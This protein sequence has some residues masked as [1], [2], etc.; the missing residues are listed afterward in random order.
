MGIARNYHSL[1]ALVSA[2]WYQETG[3][4]NDHDAA[5]EALGVPA[6]DAADPDA[7]PASPTRPVALPLRLAGSGRS[8]ARI[9]TSRTSLSLEPPSQRPFR[10][11]MLPPP[12]LR[13]RLLG[14]LLVALTLAPAAWAQ[15]DVLSPLD[16]A[17]MQTVGDV[18]VS[19]GG[20]YVAYTVSVPR[21]PFEENATPH[22]ELHVYDVEAGTSEGLWTGAVSVSG[23]GWTPDGERISLRTQ[24]E[25]DERTALYTL[26]PDGSDVQRFLMF[27]T[28]IGDYAWHPNGEAVAFVAPE[29]M[30]EE[31]DAVLPYEPEVYEEGV[32]DRHLWIA[33]ADTAPRKVD[34][35]GT[36]HGLAWSP[37]GDRLAVAAAPNALVDESYMDKRIRILDAET[38]RVLARIDNPG[39]LGAMAWSPSGR[40]LAFISAA[41]LNDPKDG[42]LM[43]ADATTGAFRDALPGLTDGQ[44]TSITWE[45]E[46]T[47]RYAV[48]RGVESG[49]ELVSWEGGPPE[50]LVPGGMAAFSSISAAE[51]G[52]VVAFAASTPMHAN[53]LFVMAEGDE[54]PARVTDLNPWLTAKRL[55][56][57]EVVTYEARDGL[58]L[59]GLLI[60]PLGRQDDRRYPAIIVVHGGPES[61]YRNGWLTGY[62][63][64][65]QMAAARGF[66][67]FYPNYR[68][69]TGRGVAFSKTSQA[70]PAGAEF[71]DIVDA[72]DHLIQIG[73]A[74]PDAI[75]VTGGSYGGYATGWLATRYSERFAAG[76]MFVGISNKVSK[77]GTT[78][79]P[80]E[81][82]HVHA[83]K[84]PWDDWQFF[85]ERSPIYYADRSETPLLILH[86]KQDPRVHPSQSLELYRHLKLRGKAPVRLV[87]YPGEGHGNRRATARYDYTLRALRWFE[88]YLQGE[89]GDPP[90]RDVSDVAA[91]ERAATMEPPG[92]N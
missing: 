46:D 77:V 73:L 29:S 69:S 11:A 12:A 13:P 83:R 4:V 71:D 25:G 34:L 89:G 19:P 23:L 62:S 32:V 59:E 85:L 44:V 60:H 87:Y 30:M 51:G 52:S 26:R 74:D 49:I 84:R 5:L 39:K 42:R 58:E 28:A 75:G 78:D 41:D 57:Q 15:S 88:H 45:D 31:E 72:A 24:R 38:G 53:E 82:Y 70:D 22:T 48:D 8:Q 20:D 79:I 47:I 56:R 6:A 17:R 86:G 10:S 35:P 16:V 92:S 81:E 90:P 3:L 76:V 33:S 9:S 50:T 40:H 68:G 1:L 63:L 2:F 27:G 66:A 36:V 54:A 64:L 80:N 37:S 43:V 91:M 67:V 61:H 7:L 55:A 65:G 18:A 14:M 21:D